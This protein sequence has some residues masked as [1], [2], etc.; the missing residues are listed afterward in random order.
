MRAYPRTGPANVVVMRL[1]SNRARRRS[2]RPVLGQA[3]QLRDLLLQRH[4][5]TIIGRRLDR[6]E[7]RARI[8]QGAMG[9]VYQASHVTLKQQRYAIKVLYGQLA[10]QRRLR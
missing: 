4:E 3:E 6:Y 8:G 7:I 2:A 5:P 10:A 9:C 1:C